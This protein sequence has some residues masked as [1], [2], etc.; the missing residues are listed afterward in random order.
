MTGEKGGTHMASKRPQ[1]NYNRAITTGFQ[2]RKKLTGWG[3]KLVEQKVA[4]IVANHCTTWASR[5]SGHAKFNP[6][7]AGALGPSR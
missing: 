1:E 3:F 2:S 7:R 4:V 5:I 6:Y